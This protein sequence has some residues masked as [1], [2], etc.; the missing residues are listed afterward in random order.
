MSM[1]SLTKN[2]LIGAQDFGS[3]SAGTQ[4]DVSALLYESDN[5][6]SSRT[7]GA[8]TPSNELSNILR[9]IIRGETSE[10]ES[11]SLNEQIDVK[12]IF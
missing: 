4:S 8:N 5:P 11:R 6:L 2:I 3:T 9:L 7:R 1:H 10:L 12:H